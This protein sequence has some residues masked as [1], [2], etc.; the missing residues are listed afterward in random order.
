[1]LDADAI[2]DIDYTGV[3]M[4]RSLLDE[5]NRAGVVL[6][7]ARAV[8]A[9]PRNLARAGLVDRMGGQQL[10][11]TVDEAVTTLGPRPGATTP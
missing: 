8:G 11:G 2:T 5:L 7:V 9:V 1:M 6:A 10:F 4:L 3:A